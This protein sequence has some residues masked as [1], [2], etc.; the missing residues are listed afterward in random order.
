MRKINW[1]LDSNSFGR[2][3]SS[4]EP[5]VTEQLVEFS[6]EVKVG[7]KEA[8]TATWSGYFSDF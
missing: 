1:Y 5:A 8:M 3:Y 7:R 4:R 2:S 6:E